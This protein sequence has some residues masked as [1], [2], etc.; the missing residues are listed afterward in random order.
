MKDV[1]MLEQIT[2]RAIAGKGLLGFVSTA[3]G[4]IASLKAA[5]VLFQFVAA[6]C[7]AIAGVVTLY[8]MFKNLQKRRANKPKIGIKLF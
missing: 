6:L 3:G 4:I 8:V 5:T 2:D 1:E 7:A